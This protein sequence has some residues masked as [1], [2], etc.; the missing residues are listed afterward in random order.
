MSTP[1][2]DPMG[3]AILDFSIKGKADD[4]I[5]SSDICD[6]DIIPVHYLFRSYDEMPEIEQFALGRCEGKILD[7]GAGA[8]MHSEFLINKGL[9]VK[10]IDISPKSIEHMRSRNIPC[11]N[12]NFLDLKHGNYNV[13]L[14]L[15]N[16]IGIAKTLKQLDALLVHAKKLVNSGGKIICDSSDIKYLYEDEEGG[17]WM[18][19]NSSYYGNFRF[20]MKYKNHISEWF[21]WLYVD[22]DNLK[23]AASRTG[24][25]ATKV[26]ENG[27]H[28][29]AEL[30]LL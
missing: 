13:L 9:Q 25:K 18:D 28:Y 7:V 1:L 22:F 14:L 10:A 11:E 23:Q 12:I 17:Y 30:T 8:G 24:W 5:V 20:Q 6:D 2:N 27:D 26:Y 16:G 19:L 3:Q 15:M 29:L 21:E 4:I